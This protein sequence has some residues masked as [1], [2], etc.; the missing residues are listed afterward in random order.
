MLGKLINLAK[1]NKEYQEE[2]C[3]VLWQPGEYASSDEETKEITHLH[4]IPVKPQAITGRGMVWTV[5]SPQGGDG[6]TT[7]ATNLAA[8]LA[9]TSPE[10]V[11]I[12][13][14]DG[15][16]AVRSRMGLPVSQCLVNILDWQDIT[17]TTDMQ[18]AMVSHSTG[19]M[20]VPGVVHYDHMEQIN[21]RFLFN[22]LTIS[23]ERF[24]HIVLD[25]PPISFNPNTW[26]AALVSDCIIT[27]LKPDRTSLDLARDNISYIHRLDCYNRSFVILNQSGIPGGLKATDLQDNPEIGIDIH[28]TLP[29]SV[30]VAEANNRRELVARAKPKDVF[31]IALKDLVKKMGGER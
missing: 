10:K 5:Q 15:I 16:G 4:N 23:K 24:D 8:L 2:E 7:V 3:P 9:I 1:K 6:A 30:F 12:I 11:I 18:R 26:A 25:C 13:D 21:P 31:S 28:Y 17:S 19:V 29:Y 20:V 14:L 22:M 27:V